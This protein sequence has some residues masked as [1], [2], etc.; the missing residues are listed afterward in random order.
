MWARPSRPA[1]AE[2]QLVVGGGPGSCPELDLER[3]DPQPGP[4]S[5]LC[6]SGP[7]QLCPRP[8]SHCP[9]ATATLPNLGERGPQ[10]S[11]ERPLL[12]EEAEAGSVAPGRRPELSQLGLC[13]WCSCRAPAQGPH[14]RPPRME[15]GAEQA[16]TTAKVLAPHS[17]THVHMCMPTHACYVHTFPPAQHT[18]PCLLVM[19]MITT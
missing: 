2:L 12:H 4:Q 18:Q 6:S 14:G 15:I 19:S 16:C 3:G 11:P 10:C 7:R 17:H 13:G 9:P 5:E 1:W 8:T